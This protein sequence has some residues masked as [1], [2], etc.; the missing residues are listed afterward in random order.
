MTGK[1]DGDMFEAVAALRSPGIAMQLLDK[2]DSPEKAVR[3]RVIKA[4]VAMG[5]D[6]GPDVV[7]RLGSIVGQ[8]ETDD[9]RSW[10][11][12]RNLMRV[13][14]QIRYIAALPYYEVMAG[15]NQKRLKYEIITSCEAMQSASAGVVLSKLALDKDQEIRKGAAIAMGNTGHPDMIKFLRTLFD[16]PRS[17]KIILVEA[18]GRIRGPQARDRLIDLYEDTTIYDN[19]GI[20]SKE[21]EQIKISILKAL[22]K[23]GD[24]ISRSKIEL[25]GS[26]KK[27]GF[28]RKDKLSSTAS[29]LLKQMG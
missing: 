11:K 4:L 24:D 14:G 27:S 10:Y 20:S 6:I 1:G 19:H 2:I 29:D 9:D 25:Y 15:W 7:S 23:I 28:L 12:L 21:R 3:A 22:S 17:E 13:L 26:K 5:K 16:D 8:G 18:L